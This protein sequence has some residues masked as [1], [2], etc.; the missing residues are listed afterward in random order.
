MYNELKINA[1]GY[2]LVCPSDYMIMK[3]INEDMVEPFS[4]KFVQNGTYSSYASPYIKE[5]FEE[6]GWTRYA[7]AY[8]WGTMG[9]VY[10]P[11]FVDAEDLSSWAGIWDSKYAKNR[12][13]RTAC[14]IPISWA[15]LTSTATSSHN[16]PMTTPQENWTPIRT[17]K[18]SKRS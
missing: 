16:S 8:M 10:N 14:A 2:D 5:L 17:G 15:S 6:N 9:F 7:A 4:D 1:A 12:P 18:L 3:M 13:S 11:A